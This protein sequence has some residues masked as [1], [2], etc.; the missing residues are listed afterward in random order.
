MQAIFTEGLPLDEAPRLIAAR[1]RDFTR[2]GIAIC[3][4]MAVSAVHEALA[5][6]DV[7]ILSWI[8][9][10]PTFID[11][12]GGV[13]AVER[14]RTTSRQVI[15]PADVVRDAMIQRFGVEPS[16]IKTL[17]YGLEAKT[18]GMSH[19][20][21]RARV[22]AELGL[23]DDAR[24]VLGCGTIDLRKAPDLFVQTARRFLTDPETVELA[25]RTWFVWIG[26][27]SD[28]T[29]H[30]WLTHDVEAAGLS[31]RI[32]FLGTRKDM[33]P[34]FLGADVFALTSREDPC[35]FANLEAM[36]SALAVV[37]F[38]GAGGAP[39]VLGESG[40]VVPYLDAGAMAQAIGR[41]LADD[42]LRGAMGRAGRAIIRRDF[43][44][45]RFMDDLLGI[46]KSEYGCCAVE[47]PKVSVIVPNYRHARYLEERLRSVF[48]QTVRPHEI[49]FLDDASGDGSVEIA[50]RLA[51]SSPVPMRVVVNDRNSGGTFKQW[52]KGLEAA[53]GDLIW[54]AES[55]DCSH[56][57]F[58]ERVLPEFHDRDVSLAYC[59]SALIGPEDEL[60][61]D[62]FLGH[63]DDVS[64]ERWRSRYSAEGATE[65]EV[66]LSQK[67]TIPNA[68]AVVFRRPERLDFADE[69]AEMR[70]AGDWLFYA[71]QIRD[72]KI[73]F[74]PEVLNYYRRHERTVSH[75]A[76]Q[77][78]THA[79]ETLYVKARIF[80]TYPVSANA[81]ARSVGRTLL[82]YTML[83]DRFGLTRPSLTAN[84]QASAPLKRIRDLLADRVGGAADLK[85]LLVID[86]AEPRAAVTSMIH[87]AGALAREHQVFLCVAEPLEDHDDLEGRIDDRVV[88]LEGTLGE[89]PWSPLDSS[90]RQRIEILRELIRFHRIDVVHSRFPRANRLVGELNSELNM[91]WFLHAEDGGDEGGRD[92]T[93]LDLAAVS[94][95]FYENEASLTLAENRPELAGTRWLKT[96]DGFDPD[97]LLQCRST[98]FRKR[99]G[100]F[101]VYL[102]D[103]EDG[104]TR[105]QKEAMDAV[106]TVNSRP[107]SERGD[108]RVRLIMADS[109]FDMFTD[110]A[111]KQ[112]RTT[113]SAP[114][115]ID[116]LALLT[117]CDAVLAPRATPWASPSSSPPPPWGAD[118]R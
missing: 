103:D 21:M 45:A 102:I 116:P 107:S 51:P 58:L 83:T 100:E 85:V 22:R 44:W 72:R 8:H 18:R 27:A 86:G 70:F 43:T 61:A 20:P 82:E 80:E 30:Q 13:K 14:I 32:R 104:A 26:Y 23:P 52:L 65:A 38:E 7:P 3:N 37:A 78:D 35:P 1:F 84:P 34:Y 94:G 33:T 11:I 10:L 40:V 106:R 57:E 2:T 47:S 25:E 101:L 77:A 73:A 89:A 39:E 112:S 96:I 62:D 12:L 5:A 90:G 63:T 75:R 88:L 108:R 67:N 66:A 9:E 36:E 16:S 29:M 50:E 19:E 64:S 93:A 118:Y 111:D 49:I 59:Q 31:D 6:E 115:A 28:H 87:L 98:S 113:T 92:A 46:L 71:L 41:L 79:E 53:T 60:L 17:R 97:A 117:H 68:S 99:E 105:F 56:P 24:I 95:V 55:D 74:V 114:R 42:A 76:V 110:Q 91:P 81:I 48:E 4:T 54:I 109:T 69:L 15:V